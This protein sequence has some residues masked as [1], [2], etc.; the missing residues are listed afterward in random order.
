[1]TKCRNLDITWKLVTK[2]TIKE[3]QRLESMSVHRKGGVNTTK[4]EE[5]Y[6]K[7]STEYK[8]SENGTNTWM[9]NQMAY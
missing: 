2:H 8:L 6:R 5:Y 3:T 7:R 4:G 1:V 9:K